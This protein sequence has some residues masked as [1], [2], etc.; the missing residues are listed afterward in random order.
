MAKE[1][2]LEQKVLSVLWDRG[3]LT[4][5]EVLEELQS[6]HAYT[7]ILTVL[8]RLHEKRRVRRRKKERAWAYRPARPREEELGNAI[9]ELLGTPGVEREPLLMAF[10]DSAESVDPDLLDRLESLIR[11]RR[12]GTA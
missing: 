12:Q 4:V 2:P 9:R 3:E 8:D 1:G 7:T 11:A 6:T 5:R 10:I